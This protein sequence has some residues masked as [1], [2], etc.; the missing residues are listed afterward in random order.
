[1][2]L[3]E[4][5]DF[6]RK[7]KAFFSLDESLHIR[8]T[9]RTHLLAKVFIEL[10]IE[11]PEQHI[12]VFDHYQGRN[13]YHTNRLLIDVIERVW[14]QDYIK[15]FPYPIKLH[16]DLGDFTIRV[17]N[18]YGAGSSFYMKN[19]IPDWKGWWDACTEEPT[20]DPKMDPTTFHGTFPILE[21]KEALHKLREERRRLLL[22][23][24]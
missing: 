7:L 20:Y 4:D 11:N 9:G 8:R 23:T 21:L 1:M 10:A 24:L 12:H 6:K 5:E 17:P 16:I 19:R 2:K 14:D 22:L 18:S 3:Y 13:Q 15:Y